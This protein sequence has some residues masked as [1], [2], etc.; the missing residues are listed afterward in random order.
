MENGSWYSMTKLIKISK[1][2]RGGIK[3]LFTEGLSLEELALMYKLPYHVVKSITQ[4]LKQ[5]ER[6]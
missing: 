1:S 2:D 5:V 4:G 6:I 3:Q